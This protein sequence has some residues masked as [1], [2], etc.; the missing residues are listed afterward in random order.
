MVDDSGIRKTSKGWSIRVSMIEKRTG[1]LVNRK[2]TISGTKADARRRRDELRA[3]LSSLVATRPRTRLSA[4][5]VSWLE[6]REGRLSPATRAKYSTSLLKHILPALGD[7]YLD[8]IEPADV[9]GYLDQRREAGAAGNTALNELRL[10]RTIAHDAHA[11]GYSPSYWCHRVEA[12]EV[13]R[14][15]SARPNLLT[16]PQLLELIQAVPKHRR[17]IVA[18]LATTGLRWGEVSALTW[19]DYDRA[20]G[21]LWIRRRNWRGRVIESTKTGRERAVPLLPLVA[22]LLGPEGRPDA[23]LFPVA[24]SRGSGRPGQPYRG[25]PLRRVLERATAKT[26]L[27]ALTP[28]GLRRSFNDLARRLTTGEVLRSITGHATEA[29]TEHYSVV[30]AGERREVSAAVSDRIGLER[31]LIVSSPKP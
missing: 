16:P 5:A 22:A 2:V 26:G 23:L 12:P 21:Q 17:A 20:G 19:A 25:S 7:L 4:Y 1:R 3:E 9:R 13:R 8:A 28:H 14:Y 30:D 18:L 15:T 27:P 24:S 29:M 6:Q 10:L 11:E 31:V